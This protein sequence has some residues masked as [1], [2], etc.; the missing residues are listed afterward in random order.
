MRI[1]TQWVSLFINKNLAL[2]FH[3]FGIEY[4]PQEVLNIIKYKWITHSVFRKEHNESI[5]YG[6]FCIAFIKYI[7]AEKLQR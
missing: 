2:Y 1:V 5:M 3:S 7:L 6:V 4:I